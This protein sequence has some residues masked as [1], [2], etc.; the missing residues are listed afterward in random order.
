MGQFR[1]GIG[2]VHKLRQLAGTEK[3][4]DRGDDGTDIDQY[5]RRNSF[6]VLHG[7]AFADNAFHSRQTDAELVLQ[8][9]TDAAKTTIS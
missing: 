2:L 7:H 6:R 1:Q 3:L 4:L 5:L 8:Q 9:F